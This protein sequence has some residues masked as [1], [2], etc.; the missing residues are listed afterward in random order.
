MFRVR[1]LTQ[2]QIVFGIAVAL[3][4]AFSLFL[5]RFLSPENMLTL[6][7]NVSVLGILGV[8]MALAVIGRGIDLSLVAL[9]AISVAWAFH[10][11]ERSVAIPLA[12]AIGF[13]FSVL[14]GA[15]TGF[16]IAYVE[17]PAIF[18][19]LAV[20]TLIYG[21]GRFFLIDLDVIYLS[22]AAKSIAWIGQGA[23]FGIPLPIYFFAAVCFLAF[24]FL[25]Y[26]KRGR[27]LRALGRQPGGGSHHRHAD[28][29]D[30]RVAVRAVGADRICSRPRHGHF[31]GEHEHAHRPLDLRLRR[32][33]RRRA[34]RHRPFGRPR[35][36]PQRDRRHAADRHSAQR[37]DDHGHPVHASRTSSRASSC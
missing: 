15:I 30:H 37:D 16:L 26:T 20:G 9:M 25:R 36:N 2:E 13:S 29:A 11:M 3:F 19:T 23:L 4:V 5:P 17:I 18:A 8:A 22:G 32:D 6:V 12:L 10:M 34:R 1:H 21:F 28:P 35:R 7:R 27:Y 24:L 14:V 31:G 33:P